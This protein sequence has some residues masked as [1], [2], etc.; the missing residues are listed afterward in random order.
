M[1]LFEVFALAMQTI[2]LKYFTRAIRIQFQVHNDF[3]TTRSYSN[4][5]NVGL[6]IQVSPTSNLL[7]FFENLLQKCHSLTITE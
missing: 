6:F 5:N 4:V 2:L 7:L 1:Y 3:R